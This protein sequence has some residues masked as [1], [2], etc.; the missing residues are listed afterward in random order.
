V[1]CIQIEGCFDWALLRPVL[2][3][4]DFRGHQLEDFLR[5]RKGNE[6]SKPLS[7]VRKVFDKLEAILKDVHQFNQPISDV[8]DCTEVCGFQDIEILHLGV[9]HRV[10]VAD[11]SV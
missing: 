4:H 9:R 11:N 5:V 6:T 8:F 1:E 2:L 10:V 7:A 3:M